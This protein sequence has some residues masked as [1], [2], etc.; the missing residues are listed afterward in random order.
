[1]FLNQILQYHNFKSLMEWMTAEMDEWMSEW[2]NGWNA[3]KWMNEMN[4]GMHECL[5]Q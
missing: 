5:N 3:M 4:E 1:M 2:M